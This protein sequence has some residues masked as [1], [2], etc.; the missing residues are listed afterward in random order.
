MADALQPLLA[1]LQRIVDAAKGGTLSRE[2]AE[3]LPRLGPEAVI[4][5]AMAMAAHVAG[6][7]GGVE[8]ASPSPSTPSA[9]VPVYEKPTTPRRRKKPGASEGHAGTRR[10]TADQ[11]DQRVE[12]RLEVCPCCGGALQRCNRTRTRVIEDIP[13]EIKPVVTEHTIHRD[14]CPGCKKHVEPVVADAMPGATLGHNAVALSAYFHYGL[15]ITISNV[16]NILGSQLHLPITPGGL[17]GAWQRMSEALL[18]W[19]EQIREQLH[20]T[21]CLHADETGWRVNGQTHWLWCFCDTRSCYYLIDKSRGGPALQRFFEDAFRGTLVTDFW[22][23]YDQVNAEDRQVCIVHLL[24]ELLKVDQHNRSLQWQQF[25]KQ[26]RRLLRDG[27]RLRKRHDFDPQKYK[28]RILLLNQR[29]WALAQATYH[30]EDASRLAARISRYRDCI[31]TFLDRPEVPADNNHA[32]RQI[33]PAV[34]QRKNIL[35]NRST[36]GA[37]TQAMLMSIF[38]TLRLRG[39]D[40]TQTIT[41]ALRTLLKTG[42]LPPLPAQTVAEG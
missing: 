4:L 26:L 21:A 11:I 40:P 31:F 2:L 1:D 6:L 35:G 28:S 9:M 39:Y 16:C 33:R 27:I 13:R 18:P 23:V 20:E 5:F 36:D 34:I 32:E 37:N 10:K 41:D 29:L 19:Y 12:H 3:A 15:G 38:R 7:A 22:A 8:T 24:R 42:K 30:D 17:L 25:A 14:Y